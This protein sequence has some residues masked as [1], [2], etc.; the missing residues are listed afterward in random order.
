MIQCGE[1]DGPV[2]IGYARDVERR[3]SNL[4]AG[5]PYPLAVVAE[6][7]LDR[8]QDEEAALHQRFLHLC[9]R[10]EW[11]R[12]DEEVGRCIAEVREL[13]RL[14]WEATSAH[15]FDNGPRPSP[16][17]YRYMLDP[18]R[19]PEEAEAERTRKVIAD[20]QR[21]LAQGPRLQAPKR[22]PGQ[23]RWRGK[24]RVP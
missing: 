22:Q 20:V 7:I 12:W 4:Q 21:F 13:R 9:M 3:R 15:V 17:L 24:V 1:A 16:E 5:C 19:N 23:F 11:H 10:G 18:A 14:Q 2:K 8:A 6:A